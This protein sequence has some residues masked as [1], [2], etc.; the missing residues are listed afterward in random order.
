MREFRVAA[1]EAMLFFHYRY[2]LSEDTRVI[3]LFDADFHF[4]LLFIDGYAADAPI[5]I[6][7]T[8]ISMPIICRCCLRY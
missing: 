2:T 4:A 8:I 6:S 7:D 5:I 1:I 3:S